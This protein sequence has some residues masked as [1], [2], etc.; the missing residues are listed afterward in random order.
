[1]RAAPPYFAQWE[2]ATSVADFLLGA[3]PATD[4]AW[5]GSGAETAEEYAFWARHLCGMA[6]LKMFLADRGEL[7]PIHTLRRAVEARGGYVHLPGGDIRGL[8][9]AGAVAWLSEKGIPARTLL[10]LPAEGIAPLLA[11]GRCFM[12]SVHPSIRWP[13]RGDPPGRG[14]HLVLVFGQDEAGRLRFHNPS[15]DT[16]AAQAD[17]RLSPADFAR[18]FAGRGVLLG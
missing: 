6:C 4:P 7:L 10:D 12:A 5:A 2:S 18:F 3:D 13:E 9:Y 17:A 11:E 14:G 1:M 8:I 16:P 15:G